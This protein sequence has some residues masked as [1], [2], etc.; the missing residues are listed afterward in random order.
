[1]KR[2]CVR[3]L[4]VIVAAVVTI[5][6]ADKAAAQNPNALPFSNVYQRPTVSPYT[7]LGNA[8]AGGMNEFGGNVA[9][10]AMIYQ[11]QILPQL[12]QQQQQQSLLRQNRQ[13][14][15]L[16][17]RVQQIQQGTSGRQIDETI[18]ATGHASTYLNLSHYYPNA[19]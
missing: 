14:G 2:S 8:G 11:N 5:G 1:M 10:P 4:A 12:Q 15:G 3:L 7:M 9:S 6:V 18:R 19:R 16:Q 17:N 13:I